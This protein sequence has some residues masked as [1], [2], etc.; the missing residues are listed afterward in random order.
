M[1]KKYKNGSSF[2]ENYGIS[3]ITSGQSTYGVPVRLPYPNEGEFPPPP[4]LRKVIL[5]ES[6]LVHLLHQS[7]P[8]CQTLVSTEA[9]VRSHWTG[10]SAIA[11]HSSMVFSVKVLSYMT[12]F[13]RC[14]M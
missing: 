10:T 9:R 6:K 11:R 1:N 8:A 14:F 3:T 13:N 12:F 4:L 2:T 7:K 5:V